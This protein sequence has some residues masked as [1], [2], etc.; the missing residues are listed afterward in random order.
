MQTSLETSSPPE[1]YLY[2]YQK[3]LAE[4]LGLGVVPR[5][6]FRVLYPIRMVE[7]FGRQRIPTDMEEI[8]LFIERA[9][10]EAGL[11]TSQEIQTF[12]GLDAKYVDKFLLFLNQIGHLTNTDSNIALTLLGLDSLESGICYQEYES[13]FM[14]YFDA[15][16][17]QPLSQEHFRVRVYESIEDNRGFWVF[18]PTFHDWDANSVAKL[19]NRNDKSQYGLMDEVVT[20]ISSREDKIVYMPVYIVERQIDLHS[21]SDLPA[22]LVFNTVK[23]YRDLELEQALNGDAIVLDWLKNSGEPLEVAINSRLDSFGIEVTNSQLR[24]NPSVGIELVL[25]AKDISLKTKYQTDEAPEKEITIQRIGKY[26]LASDW[27]VWLTCDDPVIRLEAG[28]QNCLEWLEY[29]YS[30]PDVKTIDQFIEK[31]NNRLTITPPITALKL[32]KEAQKQK[33]FRAEERLISTLNDN[34]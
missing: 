12:L 8:Q 34:S 28:I 1:K 25:D 5:R 17:N 11:T 3:A 33:M 10:H 29:V 6:L 32:K 14:L 18:P 21:T 27:C 13:S 23:G 31:V 7:V 16:G 30:E 19:Q 26:I 4:T 2:S 22:H 9:I 20:V 24:E 15:F